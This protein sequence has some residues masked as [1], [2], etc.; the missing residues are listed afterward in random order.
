[1]NTIKSLIQ[2][3]STKLLVA[4]AI[5]IEWLLD[6][7]TEITGQAMVAAGNCPDVLGSLLAVFGIGSC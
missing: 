3:H 7:H 2:Q 4:A 5:I 1:M 6:R